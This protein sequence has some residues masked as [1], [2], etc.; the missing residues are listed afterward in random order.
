LQRFADAGVPARGH[1]LRSLADHGDVGRLIALHS[2]AVGARALLIGAPSHRRFA[3]LFAQ[4]SSTDL[5][6]AVHCDVVIVDGALHAGKTAD[7][8]TNISVRLDDRGVTR[9]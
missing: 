2:N 9:V 7:N 6:R 5:D 1:L 3:D 4:S 8:A